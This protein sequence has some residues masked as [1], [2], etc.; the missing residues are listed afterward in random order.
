MNKSNIILL[1]GL[2]LAASP[3]MAFADTTFQ[4]P[5]AGA[6]IGWAKGHDKGTEYSSPGSPSG[7]TQ[8]TKPKGAVYGIYGGYNWIPKPHVLLGVEA[9]FEGRSQD[10]NTD[11]IYNG[12]PDS[13]YPVK[14]KIRSAA[15]LRG[16]LGYLFDKGHSLAFITAGFAV[17]DIKTTFGSVGSVPSS[18]S[19]T[20][21]KNGWTAG[22]GFEHFFSNMIS[23]KLE[24][25][26]SSYGTRNVSTS[27]LWS[28][29]TE[30]QKYYDQSIRLGVAYH[31]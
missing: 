5:Y 17:A 14:T 27:E 25:R 7:Y 19:D 11:Q 28:G 23:A 2:A 22:F 4:G 20:K 1:A 31:F 18:E 12:S 29:Y 16:R 24:Y 15:S 6:Q 8:L 3:T 26:Y 13:T 21:W 10:G 9:D 30:R